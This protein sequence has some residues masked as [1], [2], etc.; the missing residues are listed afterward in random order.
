M[1]SQSTTPPKQFRV[2]VSVIEL[3]VV[4]LTKLL[5]AQINSE[6]WYDDCGIGQIYF[7]FPALPEGSEE[8][9]RNLS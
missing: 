8:N 1:F 6:E 2:H 7:Q 9:H 3:F 4:Y 5:V